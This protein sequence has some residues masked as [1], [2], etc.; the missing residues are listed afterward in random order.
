MDQSI[1]FCQGP[2][3]S[4]MEVP[5]SLQL[6]VGWAGSIRQQ[7]KKRHLVGWGAVGRS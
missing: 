1:L 3:L 7:L 4:S 5:R 6:P 2:I